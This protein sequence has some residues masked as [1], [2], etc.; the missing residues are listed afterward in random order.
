MFKNSDNDSD[1]KDGNKCTGR[2]FRKIPLV[3]LFKQSYELVA[4][5]EGFY[6]G[7]EAEKSYEEYSKFAR[8][9]EV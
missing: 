5:D 1:T 4:Q 3:N 8:E 6:S 7:E 9:E 2:S